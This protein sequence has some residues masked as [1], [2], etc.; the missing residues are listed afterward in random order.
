MSDL[1]DIQRLAD[2]VR[3][4]RE[5]DG[6]PWDREQT[7]ESIKR[8]L[9]EETGEFLDALEEGDTE[10]VR[11]ELGDL[12]LQVVFHAQ[13]GAEAGE[14]NLWEIA[15]EEADKLIRRHPHVFGEKKAGDA[16]EAISVWDQAKVG[17][18]GAQAKRKSA[19]DGVP[20][21][22]PGLSRA[23]KA[24]TK[25]AKCGFEWPSVSGALSKVEEELQEVKEAA[26]E[27]NREH[28]AE[29][30]GDLLCTVANLCRINGF[31]AEELLHAATGKFIR[32][33]KYIEENAGA[34]LPETS[35]DA[36]QDLWRK[37]KKEG[38]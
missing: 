7:H 2:V 35:L 27:N 20:R 9:V 33:F 22:M 36:M 3:R 28:L 21:S 18:A 10:G 23:Q 6:C 31:E 14:Y 16:K 5:P 25:A 11:E 30:L 29:E 1:N 8:N 34:P 15:A 4:L 13:I 12:L 24:L 32:R 37:A 26:A 17:E 19:M 38:L